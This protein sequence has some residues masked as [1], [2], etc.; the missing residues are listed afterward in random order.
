MCRGYP[1]VGAARINRLRRQAKAQGLDPNQWFSNVEFVARQVN[2]RETVQYVSNIY[3]YYVAYRTAY[4]VG[5]LD[6]EAT[7]S[8]NVRDIRDMWT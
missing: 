3:I 4:G 5:K 6:L 2:G 1:A 8:K 7:V